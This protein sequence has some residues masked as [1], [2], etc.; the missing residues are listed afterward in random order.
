MTK[1]KL[2]TPKG[3]IQIFLDVD[4]SVYECYVCGHDC[5]NSLVHRIEDN[6]VD[7]DCYLYCII[8][9]AETVCHECG[10]RWIVE[11]EATM[12]AVAIKKLS[13]N[14]GVLG[15]TVLVEGVVKQI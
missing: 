7:R 4:K 11:L 10:E 14:G 13:V 3:F 9:E 1:K 2:E 8:G 6:L 12:S 15:R 5:F